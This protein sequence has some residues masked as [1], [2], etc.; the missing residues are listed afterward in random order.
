MRHEDPQGS[1]QVAEVVRRGRAQVSCVEQ[2]GNRRKL[3][4]F[5]RAKFAEMLNQ[6]V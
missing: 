1:V 2:L 6:R 4:V 5:S 3:E